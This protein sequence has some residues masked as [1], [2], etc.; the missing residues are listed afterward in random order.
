MNVELLLP[1]VNFDVLLQS[2]ETEDEHAFGKLDDFVK[3]NAFSQ[4][5]SFG[6]DF[7]NY[8]MYH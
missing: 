4:V 8:R 2:I 6:Y 3:M 5:T 1:R 7:N